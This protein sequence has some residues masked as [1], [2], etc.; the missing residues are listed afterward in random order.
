MGVRSWL[1]NWMIGAGRKLGRGAG[2]ELAVE[3]S[4]HSIKAS[5]V[6]PDSDEYAWD[7]DHYKYGNVFHADYANPLKVVVNTEKSLED[8]D[9]AGLEESDPEQSSGESEDADDDGVQHAKLITSDRFAA[10][11]RQ[12]LISQL[13]NPREQW[14]LLA[15]GIIAL[16]VLQFF[17]IIITLWTTGAF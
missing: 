7:P 4:D 17:G 12:D 13:L 1:S 5:M 9:T 8:P 14:R 10:Y 16:G 3:L 15:Y 6:N 2:L 11:M